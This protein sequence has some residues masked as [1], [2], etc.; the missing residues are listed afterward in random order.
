ME[1]YFTSIQPFYGVAKFFGLFPMSY[2]GLVPKGVIKFTVCSIIRTLLAAILLL[3]MILLIMFNHI[4]FLMERRPF[5]VNMVWS[6][7]L[8]IIYPVIFLQLILQALRIKKIR[9]FLLFM[10]EIDGKLEQ[11]VK[12]DH[13]KHRRYIICNLA[14]LAG[15]LLIRTIL[16][17]YALVKNG[18][19]V[20][21]RASIVV[22]EMC[23]LWL[24]I[25]NCMFSLQFIFAAYLLRE[26]FRALKDLLRYFCFILIMTKFVG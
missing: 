5:L 18:A 6:W 3:G 20:R 10:N 12:L 19:Q 7:F 23:Y 2:K 22:Q 26:R 25:Y 17:G 1:N 11:L 4:L 21:T 16:Q 9:S 13:Q 15:I 24:L 8:I 14:L